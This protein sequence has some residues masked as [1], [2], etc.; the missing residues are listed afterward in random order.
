VIEGKRWSVEE[1]RLRKEKTMPLFDYYDAPGREVRIYYGIRRL[2]QTMIDAY[3]GLTGPDAGYYRLAVAVI[4]KA[5]M[6]YLNP[7]S[8]PSD[9]RDAAHF[10][11]FDT[12][13]ETQMWFDILSLDKQV[14]KRYIQE[15]EREPR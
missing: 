10:L 1:L 7:D 8:K 14:V 4:M 3:G 13:P 6:D 5:V 11:L 15:I 9:Q 12:S 2:H